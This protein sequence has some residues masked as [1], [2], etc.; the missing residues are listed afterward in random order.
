MRHIVEIV[1]FGLSSIVY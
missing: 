1:R